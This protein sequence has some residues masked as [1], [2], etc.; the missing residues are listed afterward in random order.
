MTSQLYPGDTTGDTLNYQYDAMARPSS[1]GI[2]GSNP[3]ATASWGTAGELLSFN[4]DTRTYNNLGQ[5]T[6]ITAAGM[7]DMEYRY[8][9]GQNN[10]RIYQ[11]KDWITGEEVS[12]TY[13]AVN[14]LV[15]AATTANSAVTWG[16]TYTYDGFG[17]L[18]AKTPT[19]GSAPSYSASIDPS[20]NGGPNP[21][22]TPPGYAATT[23]VENRPLTGSANWSV[24]GS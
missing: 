24:L 6:R 15:G 8:T 5:L 17:N 1:M 9:T 2:T 11:S 23:D 20:T 18:T 7:M 4:G 19:A 12:Y 3:I 14:R 22:Y 13:D 10:G 21:S 16:S